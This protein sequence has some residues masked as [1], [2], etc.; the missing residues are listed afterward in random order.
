MYMY[1]YMYNTNNIKIIIQENSHF[2]LHLVILHH[3]R[4][5]LFSIPYQHGL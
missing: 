3:P 2:L 1:M 4:S 5:S